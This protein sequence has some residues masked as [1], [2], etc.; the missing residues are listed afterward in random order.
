MRK[1]NTTQIQTAWVSD[2][3][4][5]IIHDPKTNEVEKLKQLYQILKENNDNN[6]KQNTK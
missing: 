1:P 5:K 3:I 2:S 6:T 4:K